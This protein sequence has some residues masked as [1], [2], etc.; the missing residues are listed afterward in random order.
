MTLKQAI[1]ERGVLVKFV[2]KKCEEKGLKTH[3]THFS[4]WCNDVYCPREPSAYKILSEVLSAFEPISE[5]EVKQLFSKN[6]NN[7]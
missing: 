3:I 6:R 7:E 1:K 2:H 4:Q 5:E